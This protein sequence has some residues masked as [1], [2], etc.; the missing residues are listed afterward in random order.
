M[1]AAELRRV[2]AGNIRDA[3][4]RKRVGLNQLADLAGVSRAMLY[5][6]LQGRKSPTVHWL[7]KVAD[8][9]DAE[10]WRL[11]RPPGQ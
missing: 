7:T 2:L 5:L 1:G 9:L 4:R 10:P 6:V 11:L 8:A 3:A